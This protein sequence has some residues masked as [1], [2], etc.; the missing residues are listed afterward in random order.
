MHSRHTVS[1]RWQIILESTQFAAMMHPLIL[2]IIV[3]NTSLTVVFWVFILGDSYMKWQT[4][5]E[6]KPKKIV[7][8]AWGSKWTDWN[9]FVLGLVS[10]GS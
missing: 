8:P 3:V 10:K 6:D 2:G 4:D 5:P 7:T 1:L 9:C